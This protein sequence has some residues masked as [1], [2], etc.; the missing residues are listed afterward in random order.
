MESEIKYQSVITCPVCGFS[1]E[2]T[3]P[4]DACQFF[5]KCNN[6]EEILKPKKG[7]CCVFCSYGSV[8]CPPVQMER[9]EK[10]N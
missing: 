7:D 6:C 8:P 3:M 5:Y 4:A 1:K 2:E 9:R 10:K